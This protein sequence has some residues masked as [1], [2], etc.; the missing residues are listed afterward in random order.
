MPFAHVV[1]T[2]SGVA[3]LDRPYTYRVDDG[4][5]A[6]A[7]VRVPVRGRSR[8]GV[9]TDVFD[10]A[11]VPRV[12]PIR[13]VLGP[14]LPPDI[15]SVARSVAEHYLSSL[16]EALAAAIPA[17]VAS[18]ELESPTREVPPDTSLALAD[19]AWLTAYEGGRALEDAIRLDAH[20]AFA[21]RPLSHERRGRAI[22][23][24][25]AQTLRRERGALV[26]L[27]EVRTGS[28]VASELDSAFGERVAWLGSDRSDRDRYRAWLRLRAGNADVAVGG[29]AAVF[30]P[31]AR[32]GLVVI[33]DESHVSYKERR[34]PRFHA[35]PVAWQRARD[36]GAVFVAV[37]VPPSVE[38]FHA[39]QQRILKP[40]APS[41]SVEVAARPPVVV[42]DRSREDDRLTPTAKTLT[43]IRETLASGR[44]A[45]LLAHRVGEE[46]RAIASRAIRIAGPRDPARLDARTIARDADAFARACR[47]ADLIVASPV[48]AKDL[49]LANVGCVAVVEADAALAVREFRAAEEAFATWWRAGRW[50][51]QGST[52]MIETSHPGHPAIAAL[53]RWDPSLLLRHEAHRRHELGYPP[54]AALVRID[55]TRERAAAVA[56][57]V[58]AA[59]SSAEVLGPVEESGRA[60]IVARDRNRAGLISALGPLAARWRSEGTDVRVDVDPR[61]VLP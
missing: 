20:A 49:D 9:V 44:R 25:V 6:G 56:H 50:L 26:L 32:L 12:Q 48:M 33:D 18:E 17:R 24:L 7:V 5:D 14:G 27:P 51:D 43:R 11:D 47:D 58:A 19:M 52:F 61:E 37:G 15:L 1:L 35:R 38:V 40:V 60:V 30:A 4:I 28:E 23:S 41:R 31:V 34:A 22:V 55:T 53:A 13:A 10:E 39:V 29:R 46:A 54:F 36:A 45:V 3:H 8:N 21:W 57:D 42:V 2:G 59:A 16:G